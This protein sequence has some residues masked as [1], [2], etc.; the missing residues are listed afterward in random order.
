MLP[1]IVGL[2]PEVGDMESVKLVY[3]LRY[4]ALDL[5]TELSQDFLASQNNSNNSDK[6][7]GLGVDV[8]TI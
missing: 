2:L 5:S 1:S 8:C 7:F 4:Q 6:G 3:A